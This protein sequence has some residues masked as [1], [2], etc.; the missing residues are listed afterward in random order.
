MLL[1]KYERKNYSWRKSVTN[2]KLITK[3]VKS[4]SQKYCDWFNKAK[5]QYSYIYGIK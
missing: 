5:I 3:I 1:E 2:N 4:N